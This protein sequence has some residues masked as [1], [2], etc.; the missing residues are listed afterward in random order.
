MLPAALRVAEQALCSSPMGA[1]LPEQ[2]RLRLAQ[3]AAARQFGKGELLFS[4]GDPCTGFFL[5]IDGMIKIFRLSPDGREKVLVVV[6][7]GQTF[8]EAALFGDGRF[9]AYAEALSPS[10]LLFF[11]KGPFLSLLREDPDL[12]FKLLASIAT[13]LKRMVGLI[14]ELTLQ[15]ASGRFAHY[16][17]SETAPSDRTLRLALSKKDLAGRLGITPE[18]L[19]RLLADLA[20][21]QILQV[22]GRTLSI[23]DRTRLE[24]VATAGR[25]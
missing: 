16:L 12:S 23:L 1:N 14:E 5:V 7:P 20:G 2:D 11:P 21:R 6:P 17:L 9:P 25:P 8:A 4:Q 3:I 22:R 19:S 10:K 13:W 18:T 15:S 24:S